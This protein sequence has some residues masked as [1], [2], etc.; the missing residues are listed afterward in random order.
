MFT[1]ARPSTDRNCYDTRVYVCSDCHQLHDARC[2]AAPQRQQI[3]QDGLWVPCLIN[4]SSNHQELMKPF[5]LCEGYG[6]LVVSTCETTWNNM[7]QVTWS[8]I[9][10]RCFCGFGVDIHHLWLDSHTWNWERATKEVAAYYW[11]SK[12]YWFC[13]EE[14]LSKTQTQAEGMLIDKK[15]F[16]NLLQRFG[17]CMSRREVLTFWKLPQWSSY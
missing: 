8:N 12:L 11:S 9:W 7:K 10:S 13:F 6:L 16:T 17:W 1:N 4:E 2:S 15:R 5:Q 14:F 3:D